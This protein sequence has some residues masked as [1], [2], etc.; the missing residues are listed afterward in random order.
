VV[1]EFVVPEVRCTYMLLR[2][3]FWSSG[4]SRF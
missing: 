4:L 2:C 1:H 3:A